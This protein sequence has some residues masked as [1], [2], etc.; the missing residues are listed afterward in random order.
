MQSH[1][2]QGLG[3]QGGLGPQA[4]CQEAEELLDFKKQEPDS[5]F[6]LMGEAGSPHGTSCLGGTWEVEL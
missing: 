1:T 4:T 3:K 6:F 5:P 2:V